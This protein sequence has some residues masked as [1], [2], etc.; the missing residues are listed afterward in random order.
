MPFRSFLSALLASSV[1]GAVGAGIV[2]GKFEKYIRYL[3]SLICIVAVLAPFRGFKLPSVTE[4]VPSF[5]DSSI[6]SSA[7]TL[8]T[9]AREAATQEICTQI[10][11][12]LLAQTGINAVGVRIEI[13]WSDPQAESAG[14][15]TAVFLTLEETETRTEEAVDWVRSTYGIPAV[16]EL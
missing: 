7:E 8:L 10:S 13:E 9:R 3:V 11:A 2:G 14:V 12:S 5:A 15:I 6:P 16:C 4:D 1:L